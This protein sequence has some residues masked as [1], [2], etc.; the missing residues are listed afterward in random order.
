VIIDGEEINPIDQHD[1]FRLRQIAA[2]LAYRLD[3]SADPLELTCAHDG[4]RRLV[5]PVIVHRTF[6]LARDGDELLVID[7]VENGGDHTVRSHLQLATGWTVQPTSAASF[8]L[9]GHG[10]RLRLDLFGHA[11]AAV[12]EG[13][14][15]PRFGVR[16]SA[17]VIA[18]DAAHSEPVFGYRIVGLSGAADAIEDRHESSTRQPTVLHVDELTHSRQAEPGRHS[19]APATKSASEEGVEWSEAPG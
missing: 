13:W 9:L 18:L 1:L 2:P 17:P 7:E 11:R 3:P 4:Y 6:R 10:V 12:R 8:A 19:G 15:S 16:Q 14:V 5:P